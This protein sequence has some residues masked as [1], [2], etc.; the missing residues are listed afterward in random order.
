MERSH[1]TF[2]DG[3]ELIKGDRILGE[4]GFGIVEQ[5]TFPTPSGS[6]VCIRK[7]IGRPK[8]LN[9]QKKLFEAFAREVHVMRQVHHRHCVSLLGSY[10]DYDSV[11]ILSTP[12]AD[13][14]LATL[15]DSSNPVDLHH[16]FLRCNMG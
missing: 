6:C 1:L 16:D 15:L 7:R 13:M 8:Q 2:E 3:E 11:A 12:I 4:G 14:D 9:A 10:A 5:V